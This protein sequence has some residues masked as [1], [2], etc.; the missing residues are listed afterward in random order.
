VFNCWVDGVCRARGTINMDVTT[1][2]GQRCCSV[3]T[4]MP[5]H[6]Y[7]IEQMHRTWA[8]HTISE[9]VLRRAQRCY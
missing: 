4:F 3:D 5:E 8:A 1:V 6:M 9:A 7:W 2:L